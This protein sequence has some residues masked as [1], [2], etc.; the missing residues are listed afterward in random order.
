MI[1]LHTHSTAS[2]GTY[3]PENLVHYA[4]EIGLSVL[5]LT[6]HDTVDGCHQA[7]RIASEEEIE[8]ICGVEFN[9]E[10]QLG[11]FHLLGYGMNIEDTRFKDLLRMCK[12][13]RE[14]RNKKLCERFTENGIE[15]HYEQLEEMYGGEIGRPHFAD[16]LR[17]K[18]IVK[19][20]QE[21][22]D[23]FLAFGRP[24][25]LKTQGLN[26]ERTCSTI[27]KTG[28]VA[29]LAHP[30]SL[31][32]SWGKLSKK[33]DCLCQDGLDGIEA[34][35]AGT[36]ASHCMRLEQLAQDK[37]ILVTAGSDFHG[38]N[39]MHHQLGLNSDKTPINDSYYYN[40]LQ[41]ALKKA[42]QQ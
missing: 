13:N 35:N 41:E 4:K 26:F 27:K 24:F 31:Y 6:D 23:K 18:K 9:I 14:L 25:F 5:A 38:K 8:F 19:S 33:I 12:Q 36:K 29:V 17:Q 42:K 22:F 20:T 32:L 30:M 34:W 7:Q 2:D 11:E 10:T 3:S 1:D 15:I 21:G 28:G 39:K 37:H 40:G 16:F